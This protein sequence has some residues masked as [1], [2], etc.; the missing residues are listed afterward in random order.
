MLASALCN[1]QS[2]CSIFSNNYALYCDSMPLTRLYIRVYAS[3]DVQIADAASISQ[4][5]MY[6]KL[7]MPVK[8]QQKDNY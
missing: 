3:Y 5:K 2:E 4:L 1:F 6:G 7:E 8:A